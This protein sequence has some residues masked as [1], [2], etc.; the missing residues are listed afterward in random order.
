M[1]S[2]TGAA[3]LALC[4]AV[5]LGACS[6]TTTSPGTTASPEESDDYPGAVV[7]ATNAAREAEGLAPLERSSCA[8]AQAAER[9]AALVG[10]PELEHAPLDGVMAACDVTSAGE[11]LVRADATAEEVV[12]AWLG[13][14]GH[15][16]NLLS[17]DFTHVGVGCADDDGQRLCAQVFLG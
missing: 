11:N 8:D 10:A 3:A 9:A 16:N 6:G 12:E 5:L 13:S 7:A 1:R 4:A 17:A 15:R 14:P 2:S